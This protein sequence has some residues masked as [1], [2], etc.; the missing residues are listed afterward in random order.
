LGNPSTTAILLRKEEAKALLIIFKNPAGFAEDHIK[1][2]DELL[3]DERAALVLSVVT[4]W[5]GDA[6]DSPPDHWLVWLT[7]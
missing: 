1:V 7:F 6:D 5:P 2:G 4:R 3:R